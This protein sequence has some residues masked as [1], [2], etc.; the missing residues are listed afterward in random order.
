[1]ARG[2]RLRGAFNLDN[3]SPLKWRR[4]RN[5]FEH[6]DEDLDRFLLNNS[7]GYFFPDP[8]IGQH[9]LADEAIGNVFRLV[10]PVS[11]T[12]VLLGHKFEFR[13]IRAEVVRVLSRALEMDRQ[14]SRL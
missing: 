11:G 13:P 1:M 8:L 12:C 5:A 9:T 2:E 10:D 7:V 6:F 3:E 4:L 14:G